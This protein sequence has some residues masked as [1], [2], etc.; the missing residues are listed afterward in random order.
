M[1]GGG[2]FA[3]LGVAAIKAGGATPIA[4]ARRNRGGRHCWQLHQAVC[5]LPR[6]R[7]D[8]GIHRSD[9]RCWRAHG[10]PQCRGVGRIC[11]RY[12]L[13]DLGF[14][15]LHGNA[16]PW[17]NQLIAISG[18]RT[19]RRRHC[20]PMGDQSLQCQPYANALA[21][22]RDPR[23]TLPRAFGLATGV[24]IGLYIIVAIVVVGS[25]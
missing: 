8:R 18:D 24:V 10:Q 23:R 7:W 4:F 25:L 6:C 2:I 11:R 21:A 15:E 13:V 1:V 19:R 16:V 5:G 20:R 3:I 12:R 14:R 9:L 22:V 17:W